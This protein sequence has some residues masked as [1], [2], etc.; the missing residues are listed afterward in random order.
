MT[1]VL[2]AAMPEPV[3]FS[4]CCGQ[5]CCNSLNHTC[6]E[7]KHKELYNTDR[8]VPKIT[9]DYNF[10]DMFDILPIDSIDDYNKTLGIKHYIDRLT[11]FLHRNSLDIEFVD[12]WTDEYLSNFRYGEH[13]KKVDPYDKDY[14]NGAVD[15]NLEKLTPVPAILH[16]LKPCYDKT[17][18]WYKSNAIRVQNSPI[19]RDAGNFFILQLHGSKKVTLIDP[20][21]TLNMYA[22]FSDRYNLIP[23]KKKV[24]TLKYPEV[25]NAR[26]TI[27]NTQPGDL[28]YI[29]YHHWHYFETF[30]RN[31]ALTFQFN[32][33][34]HMQNPHSSFSYYSRE[35]RNTYLQHK[36]AHKTYDK[37]VNLSDYSQC[38]SQKLPTNAA[39]KNVRRSVPRDATERMTIAY[40]PGTSAPP[41][42]IL[43]TEATIS[44]TGAHSTDAMDVTRKNSRPE[45]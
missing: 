27:I 43:P 8:Y 24:D 19:H 25:K 34:N 42:S 21:Y 30:N 40:L 17:T 33:C 18:F 26:L 11:P 38:D 1:C 2:N 22:D 36:V 39:Y 4:K 7:E 23:F 41:T 10:V 5:T 29:P 9:N 35:Y 20:E 28:I 44:V 12:Q 13:S 45:S 31:I 6:I 37:L 16:T 15:Q 3:L 32:E 14:Q